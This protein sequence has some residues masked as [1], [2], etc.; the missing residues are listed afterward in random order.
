MV[1]Q[2]LTVAPAPIFETPSK[3]AAAAIHAM[4][5]KTPVK[6]LDKLVFDDF[7]DKTEVAEVVPEKKSNGLVRK[8]VGDVDLDEKDEPLLKESKR[9]FVL[10]PIQ[11]KE[12]CAS[13]FQRVVGVKNAT[14]RTKI[15]AS[16]TFPFR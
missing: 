10:F 16:P 8:Y 14:T 13:Y 11:Y 5:L 6:P 12:V 4:S 7:D 1:A 3:K 15:N 9:R 2:S